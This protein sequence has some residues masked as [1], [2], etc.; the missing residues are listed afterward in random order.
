[1]VLHAEQRRDG[2]VIWAR[3]EFKH[4]DWAPYQDRFADLHRKLRG[5]AGMMMVMAEKRPGLSDIIIS[6]PDASLGR[7]PR[8]RRG[9]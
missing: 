8:P 7:S 6:L 5:P 3:R 1:M 4:P 9:R 2:G